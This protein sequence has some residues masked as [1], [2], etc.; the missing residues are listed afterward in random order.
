MRDFQEKERK[1]L[2]SAKFTLDEDV[3]VKGERG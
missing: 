1:K 2:K 3:T